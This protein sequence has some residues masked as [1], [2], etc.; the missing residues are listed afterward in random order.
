MLP[1]EMGAYIA[2]FQGEARQY[3]AVLGQFSRLNRRL[4]LPGSAKSSRTRTK[5][6]RGG[7]RAM[8]G[9]ENDPRIFAPNQA[10][11]QSFDLAGFALPIHAL[12]YL[13]QHQIAN[14]PLQNL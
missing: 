10:P 13:A 4:R 1:C 14:D 11:Q 5:S 6:P 9:S 2:G 3:G 8:I 7:Q 12:Q